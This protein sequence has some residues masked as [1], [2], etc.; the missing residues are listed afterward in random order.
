MFRPVKA[1]RLSNAC[2]S[3]SWVQQLA[4]GATEFLYAWE[5]PEGDCPWLW[6][7]KMV[8]PHSTGMC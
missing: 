1:H 4:S 8:M 3:M 6:W 7:L 5:P 2:V